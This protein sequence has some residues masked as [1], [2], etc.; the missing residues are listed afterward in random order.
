MTGV[1]ITA[2]TVK[3]A[4]EKA[5]R[6][7]KSAVSDSQIRGLSIRTWTGGACK[8]S[9]RAIDRRGIQRRFDLG[10]VVAGDTDTDTAITLK[11]ARSRAFKVKE[12][13]AAGIEVA[14]QI[15]AWTAGVSVEKFE[16]AETEK[17]VASWSW[18]VA[19]A[20]FLKAVEDENRPE[21][22]RDYTSKL[23][24]PEIEEAFADRM[25]SDIGRNEIMKTIDK[26][27]EDDMRHGVH[28]TVRR[29]FNWLAESSRQDD[30]GV[31]QNLLLKTKP[32][33]KKV[34]EIGKP[35]E[36]MAAPAV[37]SSKAPP[38]VKLG[39]A[40]VIARSGVLSERV[41]LGIQ[42]L[43][44]TLQRRRAV[45]NADRWS[46]REYQGLPGEQAWFIPPYFRK[47]GSKRGKNFH[48]VPCVSWCAEVVHRLDK[49]ADCD[50]TN[51]LFPTNRPGE[52]E[53]VVPV[54]VGY[55]NHGL[56]YMPGVDWPP[57]GVRYAFAKYGEKY[58][59]F[60]KSEGK[61]ILDHMEGTSNDDVTGMF[62]SDDEQIKRKREMMRLWCDWLDVQ[63]AEAVAADPLLLDTEHLVEAIY[64][65]RYGDDAL[66][67]RIAYRERLQMPLWGGLRRRGEDK[68]EAA[69]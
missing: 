25:V 53:E 52:G 48:L 12:L 26:I 50:T 59:G 64:R 46:F 62:Y 10:A 21:T 6:G 16:R 15:A 9:V 69:E 30:T 66:A 13:V 58:L 47:S 18:E 67:K 2:N 42:L 7:E 20:N 1:L 17:P 56:Q 19:K 65:K 55:F 37:V 41:G 49:M 45:A 35:T 8:W 22:L 68:R 54:D 11:T 14:V 33:K 4:L 5:K 40:L 51:W 43:M 24:N 39:R 3:A 28:R 32:R 29:M 63:A 57:H 61:I 60:E 44:G 38:E 23:R 27:D 36:G 31:V 34:V